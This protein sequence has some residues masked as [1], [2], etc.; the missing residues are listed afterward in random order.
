MRARS[1]AV[2]IA[3]L[4]ASARVA[5][6]EPA[7]STQTLVQTVEPRLLCKPP[8]PSTTCITLPPGRFLDE[9]SWQSIDADKRSV[10]DALT[11]ALAE[12][13]SLRASAATY[14]PGWVVITS[15]LITGIALGIYIAK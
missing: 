11:R 6:G 1:C 4:L 2:V 14:R 9:G 12:N 3:V 15:T 8:A 13:K 5:A 7:P 10:D